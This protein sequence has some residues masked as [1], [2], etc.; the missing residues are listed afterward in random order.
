MC[1]SRREKN[2]KTCQRNK[3]CR[4]EKQLFCLLKCQPAILAS[5]VWLRRVHLLGGWYFLH[6]LQK[7]E[8]W[9]STTMKIPHHPGKE[10]HLET[11]SEKYE[12][13]FKSTKRYWTSS[14]I[15]FQWGTGCSTC[16]LLKFFLCFYF[17]QNCI[18]FFQFMQKIFED[19][20]CIIC[21]ISFIVTSKDF[22]DVQSKRSLISTMTWKHSSF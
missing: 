14:L 19:V 8:R 12:W 10:F 17:W 9:A 21:K 4:E 20:L 1:L 6:T 16:H 22:S 11:I 13:R 18:Q 2:N 7:C 15:G 3:G 5:G